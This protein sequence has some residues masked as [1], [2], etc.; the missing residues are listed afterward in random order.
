MKIAIYS[1]LLR[2]IDELLKNL[3]L[4]TYTIEYCK[5]RNLFTIKSGSRII[6]RYNED[7]VKFGDGNNGLDL[8]EINYYEWAVLEIENKIL[9]SD[10]MDLLEN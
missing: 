10:L 3:N 4:E 2:R 1:Y 8:N 9:E 7:W 5:S 6:V